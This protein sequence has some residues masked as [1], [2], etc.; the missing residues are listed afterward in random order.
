MSDIVKKLIMRAEYRTYETYYD[1]AARIRTLH[2]S[3]WDKDLEPQHSFEE[4]ATLLEVTEFAEVRLFEKPIEMVIHNRDE[5]VLASGYLPYRNQVLVEVNDSFVLG[6]KVAARVTPTEY[7]VPYITWETEGRYVVEDITKCYSTGGR[8]F[9]DV[10]KC[11]FTIE[12]LKALKE[13]DI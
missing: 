9:S 5:L 4:G 1:R 11:Y 7:S 13:L 8:I 12:D 3:S 2:A 6:G 10:D